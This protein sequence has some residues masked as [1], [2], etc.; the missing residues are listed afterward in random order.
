MKQLITKEQLTDFTGVSGSIKD[1]LFDT[2]L[3]VM[4]DVGLP[5]YI[6]SECVSDILALDADEFGQES[7]PRP[8]LSAFYNIYVAKYVAWAVYLHLAKLHGYNWANQGIVKFLENSNTGAP[9]E[10]TER[11]D[12]TNQG[13]K[14]KGL[15]LS[16][17]RRAF[18]NVSGTFDEVTY[19]I[20][21]REYDTK[22][23]VENV[24]TRLSP[25]GKVKRGKLNKRI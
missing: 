9:I 1:V 2:A 25:I 13:V 6:S 4:Q 20:D 24:T 19:T 16:R 23:G 22:E 15:Y 21:E 17:M 14:M 8:E 11:Q 10:P 3:V 12:L 18:L 5:P 7:N